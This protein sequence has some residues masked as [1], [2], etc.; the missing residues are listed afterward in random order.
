MTNKRE[1]KFKV[2]CSTNSEQINKSLIPALV[3][4]NEPLILEGVASSTSIDLEGDNMTSECI[5]SMKQQAVGLSMFLDHE[6][7]VDKIIGKVEEVLESTADIF[8]IKFSILP[9]YQY[10]IQEFLDAG[11]NL[12]LSIGASVLDYEETETGWKIKEIKLH[13]ISVVGIPAN[14]DSLGTVVATKNK[15]EEY[16][17]AKCFNGACKQIIK[18]IETTSKELEDGN[19]V[20]DEIIT[21]AEVVNMI[22]EAANVLKDQIITEIVSEFNLDGLKQS[23][24]NV[25]AT[26]DTEKKLN[27][28]TEK[29]EFVSVEELDNFKKELATELATL[30]DELLKSFE[31]SQEIEESETIEETNE[32]EDVVEEELVKETDVST[33]KSSEEQ[34]EEEEEEIVEEQEDEEEIK[35]EVVKNVEVD[36]TALKKELRAEIESELFKELSV[37]R[38][39]ESTVEVDP[40]VEDVEVK[41]AFGARDIAEMLCK[42]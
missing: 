9:S 25:P 1:F 3:D 33:E 20:D 40:V 41:K 2:Y 12:G 42:Q 38:E 7:C 28:E 31:T 26:D 18:Q 30:K 29:I 6:H 19:E 37:S 39:P 5:E 4:D 11:I 16:V 10:Y 32:V 17:V 8:K 21:K 24:D 27:M 34:E 23:L 14:Q 15:E 35:E 36:I 13:E 22:N